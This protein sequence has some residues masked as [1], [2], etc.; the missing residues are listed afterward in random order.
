MLFVR[1]L[2]SSCR[3]ACLFFF[4]AVEVEATLE[5]TVTWLHNV[6]EIKPNG[7]PTDALQQYIIALYWSTTTLATV[8]ER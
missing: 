2:L 6:R 8:R 7:L 4:A 3:F 5:G 1:P